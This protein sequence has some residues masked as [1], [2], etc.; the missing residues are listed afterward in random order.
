SNVEAR[1]RWTVTDLEKAL[2]H[3]VRITNKKELISWWDD[4]NYLHVRGFHEAK[5][6]T[7]SIK[8]RLASIRKLVEYAKNAVKSEKSEKI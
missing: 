2:K 6:D 7:E 5:L 4:A 3:I 8:L 1:G